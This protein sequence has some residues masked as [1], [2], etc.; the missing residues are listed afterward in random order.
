MS[1]FYSDENLPIDLVQELRELG[2]DILTSYEAKQANQGIPDNEVLAYAM[3]I[4]R[5]VITLNRE[6]F[7]VLH[8]SG[9][10]HSGIVVCKDDRDYQGQ[11]RSLHT[12]LTTQFQGLQN[13]LIRVQ[14]QNQPRS[15]Q[16]IF[17]VREYQR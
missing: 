16:K 6:D 10:E 2:Y 8:R 4:D 12:Y 5:S 15:Q 13:R 11:A 14:K 17:I 1:Q 9:I 7:L 3:A